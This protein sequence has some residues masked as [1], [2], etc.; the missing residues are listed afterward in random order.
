MKTDEGNKYS[1]QDVLPLEYAA[2]NIFA[3]VV[4]PILHE[5][6]GITPNTLTFLNGVLGGALIVYFITTK[7]YNLASIFL[8]IRQLFDV[9]DGYIARK[10]N[11]TSKLGA[12]MD[13]YS[14]RITFFFVNY[15]ILFELWKRSKL[16]AIL[17]FLFLTV[18]VK[19]MK[20]KFTCI[21]KEY[22]ICK[23]EKNRSDIL[24]LTRE[25]SLMEFV[26]IQAVILY[27]FSYYKK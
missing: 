13:L 26:I 9:L 20:K 21:R 14:D 25:L 4:A 17:Y 27:S 16:S 10:Y 8:V 5:N 12:K 15:G 22:E 1:E 11:L 19:L 7:Q 23:D 2:Y 3:P 6:L 18:V 24:K